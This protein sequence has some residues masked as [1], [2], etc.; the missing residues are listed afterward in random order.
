MNRGP[1]ELRVLREIVGVPA[2]E[3]AK[4]VGIDRSRLSRIELRGTAPRQQELEAIVICLGFQ[5]L[6]ILDL[7]REFM[8]DAQRLRRRTVTV[9]KDWR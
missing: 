9:A 3:V 7:A 8:A 1:H 6:R 2:S 4:L 5:N